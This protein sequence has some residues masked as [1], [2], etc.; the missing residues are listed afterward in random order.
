MVI[1]PVKVH[2]ALVALQQDC[3]KMVGNSELTDVVLVVEIER[4]PAHWVMYWIVRLLKGEMLY[5]LSK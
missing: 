4:F 2:T 1:A 3:E 5:L